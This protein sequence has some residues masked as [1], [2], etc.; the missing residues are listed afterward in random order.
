MVD[1][2]LRQPEVVERVK[3]SPVT[4]WRKEKAGE[5]PKRRRL[6]ANSVC[7]LESEI[8]D[9]LANLPLADD[10]EPAGS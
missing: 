5:F 9:W 8:S 7:W 2:V 4:L 6:G 1:K 3:L 10:T